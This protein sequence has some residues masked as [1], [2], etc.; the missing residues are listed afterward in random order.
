MTKQA[1]KRLALDFI[2][3]CIG[4]SLAD[5]HQSFESEDWYDD[6]PEV[7]SHT[8]YTMTIRIGNNLVTLRPTS[9]SVIPNEVK[10]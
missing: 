3:A 6:P 1:A 7:T 8:D 5:G 10:P 4:L 9:V 2:G